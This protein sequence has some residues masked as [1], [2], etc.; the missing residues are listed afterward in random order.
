MSDKYNDPSITP[1]PDQITDRLEKLEQKVK[2]ALLNT[3]N[4]EIEQAVDKTKSFY[5]E[6]KRTIHTVLIGVVVLRVYK[7]KVAKTTAKAVVKAFASEKFDP[8]EIAPTMYDIWNDLKNT[9]SLAY[10]PHGGGMV[11]LLGPSKDVVVTVFGNFEKM[12]NDEIFKYAG[13]ALGLRGY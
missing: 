7:R 11:H 2:E 8:I 12:R 4:P 5:E 6:N 3:G 1:Q 9:P 13:K 10:I